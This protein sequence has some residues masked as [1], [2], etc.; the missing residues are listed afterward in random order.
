MRILPIRKF[1]RILVLLGAAL[2]TT[3]RAQVTIN[4]SRVTGADYPRDDAGIIRRLRGVGW[5]V[6]QRDNRLHVDRRRRPEPNEA[7][8]KAWCFTYPA[9]LVMTGLALTA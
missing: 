2:P 8:L 9:E 3:S 6:F 5:R 7:N 4:M 1:V